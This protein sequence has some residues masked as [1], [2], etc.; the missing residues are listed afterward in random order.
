MI[1]QS[2]AHQWSDVLDK[3]VDI[4]EIS[5]DAIMSYFTP[6]EEFIEENEKGFEYKSGAAADEQFEELEKHILQEINAPTTTSQPIIKISSTTEAT[7]SPNKITSNS[8]NMQTMV[9]SKSSVY[10]REDKLKNPGSTLLTNV[11]SDKSSLTF[12]TLDTTQDNTSEVNTSKAVWAVSAV[13][14]AIVIICIIAIFGR[15][16]CRKMP[17]NRRYV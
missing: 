4:D 12:D 14:I 7:S 9:K 3:F 11:S 16:R 2:G 13:L 10:I 8:T 1:Q 17:K 6:L 15:R 5:A